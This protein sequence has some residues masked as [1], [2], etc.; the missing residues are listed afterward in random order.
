M[1][2]KKTQI[3]VTNVKRKVMGVKKGEEEPVDNVSFAGD[4]SERK[5][6]SM[7]STVIRPFDSPGNT[8]R[9]KQAPS[10]NLS[11]GKELEKMTVFCNQK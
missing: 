7:P 3:E 5:E 10:D 6:D 9:S 2:K 8:G 1:E 4:D 11:E